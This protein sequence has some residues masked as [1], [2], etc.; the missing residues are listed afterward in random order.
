MQHQNSTSGASKINVWNIKN[1]LKF[2]CKIMVKLVE[3]TITCKWNLIKYRNKKINRWNIRKPRLEYWTIATLTEVETLDK[4]NRCTA[5]LLQHLK[6]QPET[7]KQKC[8][9][10]EIPNKKFPTRRHHCVFSANPLREHR[11]CWTPLAHPWPRGAAPSPLAPSSKQQPTRLASGHEGTMASP[12][13]RGSPAWTFVGAP[14]WEA[15]TAGA[16]LRARR[17]AA[18]LALLPSS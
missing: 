15:R 10:M 18:D 3:F 17:S 11:V 2:S 13:A 1:M 8:C 4:I 5:H 12:R 14:P 9:N 6:S 7:Y 16:R